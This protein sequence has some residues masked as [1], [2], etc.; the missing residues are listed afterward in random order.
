MSKAVQKIRLT[1]LFDPVVQQITNSGPFYQTARGLKAIGNHLVL[2]HP[3]RTAV[4]NDQ[5]SIDHDVAHIRAHCR[6]CQAAHR[7]KRRLME[8]SLNLGDAA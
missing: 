7:P 1:V 5:L 4:F 3:G 8:L 2:I 6:Q